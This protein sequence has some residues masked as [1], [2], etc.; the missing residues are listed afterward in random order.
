MEK[1]K[2]QSQSIADFQELFRKLIWVTGQE[3]ARSRG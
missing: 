1:N 2:K 3:E